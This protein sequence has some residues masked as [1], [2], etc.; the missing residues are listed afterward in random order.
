MPQAVRRAVAEPAARHR[1]TVV[2]DETMRDLDLR[3][4]PRPVPRIRGAVL[5]GS[6]SKAIRGGLRIGWIRAGPPSSA[7]CAATPLSGPLSAPPMRQPVAAELLG[8]PDSVLRHRVAEPRRRRDRL[9]ALLR[10]GEHREFDVP[11]GGLARWLRLTATAADTAVERAGRSGLDLSAG[12]RLAADATLTHH[13][14][15]PCTPPPDVLERIADI[16]R[17]ACRP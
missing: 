13:P 1:V 4:R 16:V 11:P 8:A 10:T 15:V 17:R 6:V 12:P 14:R 2:A 7:N 9:T 5:I 3:D